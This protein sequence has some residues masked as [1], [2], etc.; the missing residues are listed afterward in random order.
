MLPV[1]VL[2]RPREAWSR[3]VLWFRVFSA[4]GLSGSLLKERSWMECSTVGVMDI[5]RMGGT[6]DLQDLSE[7]PEPSALCLWLCFRSCIWL[8]RASAEGPG[9]GCRQLRSRLE[10]GMMGSSR[11]VLEAD[12]PS[13]EDRSWSEEREDFLSGTL[14]FLLALG[15]DSGLGK[16]AVGKAEGRAEVGVSAW[17]E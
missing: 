13:L 4:R 10:G 12:P 8:L 2:W 9:L 16:K 17:L 3:G 7:R 11:V 6:S 15:G 5:R 14:G 1:R